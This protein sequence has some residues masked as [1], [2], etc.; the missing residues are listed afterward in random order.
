M[1]TEA[2][3]ALV[4]RRYAAVH[5]AATLLDYPHYRAVG[6]QVAPRAVLGW[7]RAA[8]RPLFLETY[9][10]APIEQVVGTALGRPVARASIV[11]IGDHAS[12]S[13]PATLA[14][15]AQ[16]AR[17][18][19]DEADVGVAVLTGTLRRMFARIGLPVVELAPAD[20]SRLPA[21]AGQ[22]GRYYD[23]D[24]VVCAGEIATGRLA[25]EGWL[26]AQREARQ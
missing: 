7:R 3:R 15:W 9:L 19:C 12:C 25:L 8:D 16:T 6:D 5:G 21:G 13:G 20:P 22:W 26:A 14:L 2:G 17:L 4:R 24:P 1:L 10:D 23:A 18:L 11:E